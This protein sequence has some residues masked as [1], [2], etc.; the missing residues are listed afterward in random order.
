MGPSSG[1][2][3][4]CL[5]WN[6]HHSTLV[7]V[8]DAL[9]QKGSLVDVTLAAEG[10]SIQ[11]HRLV[12][13]ACSNYFQEL[14]SL[15]WD[16]QAV[17]FLKDVKFDHLQALVDYMYRGEVNVSQDQLAAFLNTAEAL[18]I[19]GLAD[20]DRDRKNEKRILEKAMRSSSPSSSSISRPPKRVRKQS[21]EDTPPTEKTQLPQHQLPSLVRIPPTAATPVAAPNDRNESPVPSPTDSRPDDDMHSN[22]AADNLNIEID[23]GE[24]Y[25]IVEPKIETELEADYSGGSG[26]EEDWSDSEYPSRIDASRGEQGWND[27]AD[28]HMSG[29]GQAHLDHVDL[30]NSARGLVGRW[31]K[32]THVRAP[33]NMT[34][35]LHQHEATTADANT[36]TT[37]TNRSKSRK[38]VL[39]NQL[40]RYEC[41][42]CGRSYNLYGNLRRHWRYDCGDQPPQFACSLCGRLFRRRS[43]LRAH[44][45]RSNC[46]PLTPVNI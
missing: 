7:S 5:R 30:N 14:L 27:D 45:V 8:M 4:Y 22:S 42:R 24:E 6:N 31:T 43:N 17:V 28:G 20:G 16:K 12:L 25:S 26:D 33:P 44:A 2:Q 10:K 1:V 40:G 34:H 39:P 15:H 3:E 41:H 13:C 37:N 9:L 11:V 35:H 21:K 32:Q 38:K 19:K 46:Q 23:D 29:E 18:K 36:T